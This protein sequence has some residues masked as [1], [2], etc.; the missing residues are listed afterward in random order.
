MGAAHV[1]PQ[2]HSRPVF[3]ARAL[4]GISVALASRSTAG[5]SGGLITLGDHPRGMLSAIQLLA[6]VALRAGCS[7]YRISFP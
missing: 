2:V 7:A 3:A 5:L 4:R 1:R 6:F